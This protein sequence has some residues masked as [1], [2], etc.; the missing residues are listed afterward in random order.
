[1]K[2]IFTFIIFLL[3]AFN[4]S[5]ADY[6]NK[7]PAQ[8]KIKLKAALEYKKAGDEFLSN[9]KIEYPYSIENN[10]LFV[11]LLIQANS[12]NTASELM[13]FGCKIITK[14]GNI[15]VVTAPADKIE[16]VLS[17]NSVVAAETSQL[18]SLLLDKS[19]ASANGKNVEAKNNTI[20]GG[21][22]VIVGVFDTGIDVNHPD[23]K[24]ENGTRILKLWDM[25]DLSTDNTPENFDY[26]REYTKAQIDN[27]ISSV[28]QKDYNGHG[29]HVA[30]IAAGNGSAAQ[31]FKGVAYNSELLIVKGTRENDAQFADGDIISGCQYIF[32]EAQ[33]LG[34]P[35]VIN[36]SLGSP[37]GPHDGTGLLAL[38]ISSLVNKGN[39]IVA[40][41]GNNGDLPIHAG[42][43]IESGETVEFPIYPQNLCEMFEDFCPDI[44]NFYMTAADIWYTSSS[45]DSC[46]IAAYI[47]GDNGFE[48]YKYVSVD[49]NTMAENQLIM[50]DFGNLLAMYNAFNNPVVPTNSDGNLM[51]QLHNGGDY[52]VP[53]GELFWSIVLKFKKPSM[54]DIW[55]GIPLPEFFPFN[56]MLGSKYF[57]G[58]TNM[59]IGTPGDAQRVINVASHISKNSW[60]DINQNPQE[61]DNIIG[62][63]SNFSSLGPSRDGRMQPLISAPGDVIF[64]ARSMHEV[65]NQAYMLEGGMLVGKSGTS[66]SAPIVSGA[67]ALMLQVNPNL[68]FEDIK[69]ILELTAVKDE[70]TGSENNNAFG[71]GKLDIQAAIDYIV[72][73]TDVKYIYA[74]EIKVYPNPAQDMITLELNELIEN[75]AIKIYN[76]NGEKINDNINYQLI[77][78]GDKSNIII[79][80]SGLN[81]GI[82]NVDCMYGNN[83]AKFR[84]VVTRK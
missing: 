59:T 71:Y 60:I 80:V 13:K 6:L 35:A 75:P 74:N 36:L 50:D 24:S 20:I 58:N 54:V 30:G 3:V 32:Q 55:A 43:T 18:Y 14:A 2:S 15:L 23:F 84:F 64:A 21:E 29:T 31:N 40:S 4:L 12:P 33:K 67:V 27:T 1:M 63:L 82:Y 38:A 77:Q 45:L 47:F 81:S 17:L 9:T 25:S 66:M 57:F 56:P 16:N 68:N 78:N 19:I 76:M 46:Y 49:L 69:T 65:S 37:I 52:E 41:A 39:I 10:K 44:P 26:G 70:F 22:G 62:D 5:A 48:L 51:I 73:N 42:G 79:N 53:V 72:A 83:I 7:M 34:K 61:I 28:N 11:N 8:S